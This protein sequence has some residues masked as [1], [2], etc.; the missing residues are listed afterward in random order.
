[1]LERWEA[2]A[3]L[4]AIERH[5]VTYLAGAPTFLQEMLA[6]PA[7]ARHHLRSL[8]LYSCGGASVPPELIRLAR[9][10]IPAMVAK[11]SYGSAEFPTIATTT[12]ADALARGLDTEGR[13]LAEVEIRITGEDGAPLPTGAEGE[14]RAR[15]PECFLGYTD[16]A[17]DDETFDSSGFYRTGDL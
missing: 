16:P 1:L 2:G 15:G 10:R 6:H 12:A 13:A 4:A 17:L 11:R 14:I 8:R 7:I 9:E 3:A 5:E